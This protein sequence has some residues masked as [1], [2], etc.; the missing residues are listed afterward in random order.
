MK[1]HREL[2]AE[3][4]R[5]MGFWGV[6][7]RRM[8]GRRSFIGAKGEWRWPESRKTCTEGEESAS[9]RQRLLPSRTGRFD[10]QEGG[11]NP[12]SPLRSSKWVLCL[13]ICRVLSPADFNRGTLG[14]WPK[15]RV[16]LSQEFH[17][18][19]ILEAIIPSLPFI[20]FVRVQGHTG[21]C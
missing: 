4:V 19:S 7:G 14:L 3:L 5:L 11:A 16:R 17:R 12:V 10:W 8:E 1:C 15:K 6:L 2:V 18:F 9:E 21:V 20:W 13:D